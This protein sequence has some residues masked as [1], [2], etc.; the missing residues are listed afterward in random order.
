MLTARL[1]R[2]AT[3]S[4]ASRRTIGTAKEAV[5]RVG[6][7]RVLSLVVGSS[8][9]PV[10]EAAIPG[11][12]LSAGE[13]WRH[14]LAAALV[15]ELAKN[16]CPGAW[17]PLAFTAALLH[18]I[19]KLVLGRFLNAALADMCRRAVDE[20]GLEHFEAESEILRVHHGEVGG[21]IAQHWQLPQGI[22]EGVMHHHEPE[23]VEDSNA[24]V[25]HL[26]DAVARHLA[27]GLSS[28]TRNASILP[29]R[30]NGWG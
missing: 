29:Q 3:C 17:S 6:A 11:Y 24:V 5:I 7:G 20:G 13:L 12:E 27:G 18:D 9:Q 2:C 28:S 1:L 4:Y 26:G 8:A 14:S 10:M 19:G 15:A 16:F 22:V 23:N 21:I 30:V 25:A